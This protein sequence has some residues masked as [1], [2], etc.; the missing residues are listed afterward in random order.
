MFEGC[1]NKAGEKSPQL[2][3]SQSNYKAIGNRW[4]H[5]EAEQYAGNDYSRTVSMK[6]RAHEIPLITGDYSF[7][8]QSALLL[9]EYLAA[10]SRMHPKELCSCR[11]P[12]C[13]LVSIRWEA[14]IFKR[15]RSRMEARDRSPGSWPWVSHPEAEDNAVIQ[16]S[17]FPFAVICHV[18]YYRQISPSSQSCRSKRKSLALQN[19]KLCFHLSVGHRSEIPFDHVGKKRKEDNLKVCSWWEL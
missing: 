12:P 8:G 14:E 13:V 3:H 16:N 17:K 2:T 7:S 4:I 9:P 1:E 18:N 6:G 11:T 15:V 19:I 5:T 10:C